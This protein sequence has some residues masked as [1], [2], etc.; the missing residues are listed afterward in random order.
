MEHSEA[1]INC[2]K[3][4]HCNDS[5]NWMCLKLM[6]RGEGMLPI[7]QQQQWLSCRNFWKVLAQKYMSAVS[8]LFVCRGYGGEW[9]DRSC[10]W[11][12]KI[13]KQGKPPRTVRLC[14]GLYFKWWQLYTDS[15]LTCLMS[16]VNFEHTHFPR[17]GWNDV[18]F[19]SIR[20][21]SIFEQSVKRCFI[22]FVF[23]IS[24]EVTSQK[25]KKI[26]TSSPAFMLK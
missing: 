13:S 5:N 11:Q 7:G 26:L 4:W 16:F 9:Q 12:R 10:I 18:S 25:N 8:H 17:V 3:I 15:N 24:K 20:D 19:F 1:I 14:L 2:W 21:G 6:K 23:S 22:Y